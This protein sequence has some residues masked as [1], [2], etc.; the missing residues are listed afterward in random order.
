[1]GRNG[2]E[3]ES[4][5]KHV[6]MILEELGLVDAKAV[7]TPVTTSETKEVASVLNDNGE[8]NDDDF[9]SLDD[10]TAYKT[11]GARMNFLAQDRT[12][13]QQ[14]CRCVCMHMTKQMKGCSHLLERA[15]RYLRGGLSVSRISCPKGAM[16]K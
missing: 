16:E 9:M 1:M 10:A 15:A 6:P 7:S 3:Y 13:I 8:V 14:A 5:E 11:I 4:D 12:D 2:S